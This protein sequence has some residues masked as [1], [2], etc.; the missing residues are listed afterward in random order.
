MVGW[1]QRQRLI[2]VAAMQDDLQTT[3]EPCCWKTPFDSLN[4]LKTNA[5]RMSVL[6]WLWKR[7]D[8]RLN[9]LLPLSKRNDSRMNVK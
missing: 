8:S 2:M 7:N 9:V 5:L 6:L 3:N 1:V 4:S